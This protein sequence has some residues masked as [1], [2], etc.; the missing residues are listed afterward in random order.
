MINFVSNLPRNL[1][2]GGFSAMNAAACSAISKFETVHYVGPIN[3][4]VILW[5]K[6]TSKFRRVAGSQGSFF[7]FSEQRLK[8]IA[9]EVHSR[10][11][12]DARLDF[13]HGFTPWILTQ[14]QHPYIAWS[15]CNFR[16][17]IDIFHRREQ[18]Y[19][20]DLERIE[21]AEASW[22]R[23]AQRV[24]FT[25]EWAAQRA[26]RDYSLDANRVCSVGIF[27]ELDM[28][29]HDRYLGGKDFAFVSTNFE[30]KG[31]RL[32]LAAFRGIRKFHPDARL[33]VVGDRPSTHI[34]EPGVTFTGFLRKEIPDEYR[35]FRQVLGEA[36]ALV[37]ASKS[38]TCPV[39]LV[40]AG[41]VGCPVIS[42]RRFAIAEII[43]HG[44]NGLLLD[45]YSASVVSSAMRWML[46]H[47]DEYREMRQAAWTKARERHSKEDSS[48]A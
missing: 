47:A 48:S 38:D 45:E 41:Y 21:E 24:L 34:S 22:L 33:I 30:T 28:P 8:R 4:S 11:Q 26:V 43:E 9:N 37:N 36:R 23:N 19:R 46:E 35:R 42:M 27:G 7:F 29:L 31:G 12:S 16:D 5:Q 10:A 39:L 20:H 6:A 40:E 14:P 18:F 44:C 32:V 2:S 15:D 1:R 13:F 25:S 3:P 17:Y